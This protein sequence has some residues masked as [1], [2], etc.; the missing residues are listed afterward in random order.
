MV[1]LLDL[2]KKSRIGKPSLAEPDDLHKKY[3]TFQRLLVS[4]N[5]AL[6]LIAD[7]E[8]LI[9]QD[10]PFTFTYVQKRAEA[11][12]S[13]VFSL[14]EDLNALSMAKFIQLF[15]TLEQ[16][17]D[18]I[19]TELKGKPQIEGT[20]FVFPLEWLS[21]ESAFE[22]GGKAANLGEVYNRVHLPVPLGFAIS[23]YAFQQFLNHNRLQDRFADA[24]RDLDVN[25]TERLIKVSYEMRSQ[26]MAAEIPLELHRAIFSA[27][28]ELKQSIR[29]PLRFSVRSSATS[30]DSEAS[31]AGQHSTVLNVS[32][33]KLIPAYKEVVSSIFNPRAIFYRRQRGYG[34]QDVLM[35]VACI[36]MIDAKASGVMYTVDPND[37]R[38]SVLMI[39]S[40][41]GLAVKAVEGSSFT[42][43]IRV[44]KQT[45]KVEKLAIATKTTHLRPDPDADLI[46][47]AVAKDLQ[48]KVSLDPLQID[49]LVE[50]ALK[51]EQH[52][53]YALDIE[54]AIDQKGKLFI[55]QA[56]P[57]K[58]SQKAA[59]GDTDFATSKKT[60]ISPAGYSILLKSGFTASG[61][62]AAGLAYVIKSDHLLHRIPGGS[63]IIARNT[64]PRYVPLMGRIQ[65]II[66][67][68]GNVTGHMASVAREFNIPMLVGTKSATQEIPHGAELTLDARNRVVYEGIVEPLLLEKHVINPMKG[69]PVYIK[70]QSILKKIA[71]LNL[72][73]P[74]KD[75]FKP[76]ACKTIHDVI[77]FS[78]EKAMQEM[79]RIGEDVKPKENVAI[80]L[81]VFLPI[82]IYIIDL[83]GGLSVGK[84]AEIATGDDVTSIPFRALLKGMT[85]KDVDWSCNASLS[86]GGLGSIIAQSV[87]RD[88]SLDGRLGSP[89]YAVIGDKYLNFN[90]RIGYHF[91]TIDSYC[92]PVVN[93][94]YIS[95]SFK[96]GA[97]DIGRRTRRA[98]L[99]AAILKK[100]EF[101]V[102]QTGDMIRG[103]L[104]KYERNV[105]ESKLDMLGRL[106]GAVNLL[107]RLL[108][109]TG[110][111]EWYINEFFKGNYTFTAKAD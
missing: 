70:V 13:E 83:G 66:T 32:E 64:S 68:V 3:S 5:R 71:P 27:I 107:D 99:I 55:L 46:E 76:E 54:W 4:N 24:L 96:G 104:K 40:L 41:W 69:S 36:Q 86:I 94:N 48:N 26:V 110:M 91:A 6:E 51:L 9:F 11:L 31:F 58:R 30:E 103:T 109:D 100:M 60:E 1:K 79:F 28:D 17:T 108:A 47:E 23:A 33:E 12:I 59:L 95:F 87:I 22:V 73:D 77:R 74:K 102:E 89:T 39:S 63:I 90:S 18:Q 53:G 61:G 101:K 43:F 72:I 62:V 45:Q 97:A 44:N 38:N 85:H 65:G 14:V 82:K 75:N 93:D 78:H 57:L 105:M 84:E 19:L 20:A 21:H 34:D 50:Y 42:D 2:F 37:N 7:L 111:I 81:R 10:M 98:L 29:S 49:L 8:N 52:Y 92:G 88:P 67:D 25:D 80:P 15:T 106:M 16:I 56:R 35:G